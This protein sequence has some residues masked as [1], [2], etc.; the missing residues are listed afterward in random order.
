MR[1]FLKGFC[2]GPQA[3]SEHGRSLYFLEQAEKAAWALAEELKFDLV[4][5][6]PS[7]V[8]GPVISLLST[9]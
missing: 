7:L 1:R 8:L 3:S 4:T 6:L 5:V 9:S 2:L